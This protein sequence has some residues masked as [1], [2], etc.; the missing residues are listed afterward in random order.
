MRN[1]LSTMAALFIFQGCSTEH[2][3][4]NTDLLSQL[5]ERPPTLESSNKDKDGRTLFTAARAPDNQ[6][7]A[8]ERAEGLTQYGDCLALSG[9]GVRSAAFS[10]GVLSSLNERPS[11]VHFDAISAVSGGGYALSWL[12][13]NV[14]RLMGIEKM[15]ATDAMRRTLSMA[16]LGNRT[17]ETDRTAIAALSDKSRLVTE[18]DLMTWELLN[19]IYPVPIIFS[20]FGANLLAN[21]AFSWRWNIGVPRLM[22]ERKIEQTFLQGANNQ[23]AVP[24]IGQLRDLLREGDGKTLPA[25]IFNTTAWLGSTHEDDQSLH[26]SV[27]SF[28]S[29]Q[30]GSGAYGFYLY[31]DVTDETR[32]KY[33]DL[34]AISLTKLIATSG[35][36]IDFNSFI[37]SKAEQVATSLTLGNWGRYIP[38]PAITERQRAG[39]NI[40]P[41]PL[42]FAYRFAHDVTGTSIYLSDGGHSENLGVLPL[43]LRGC[44]R[45]TIVDAEEDASFRF[46]AYFLLRLA[47][48]EEF[49]LRLYVGEIEAGLDV[50]SLLDVTKKRSERKKMI[51]SGS[52]ATYSPQETEYLRHIGHDGRPETYE[53]IFDPSSM[54]RWERFARK[55]VMEGKIVLPDGRAID[56]RYI[57]LAYKPDGDPS[58]WRAPEKAKFFAATEPGYPQYYNGDILKPECVRH[59]KDNVKDYYLCIKQER[60]KKKL[61][62]G[63]PSHPFPQQNTLSQNF[64][65]E[66]FEA[67]VALGS[68]IGAI[69]A[70]DA[71]EIKPATATTASEP[72]RL[73]PKSPLFE[74]SAYTPLLRRI[75]IWSR[76]HPEAHF[77]S[78]TCAAPV[79]PPVNA[80]R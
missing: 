12:Y 31:P 8:S 56:I 35:G 43:I 47:L 40:L 64:S 11:L 50:E 61:Y 46:E 27:F 75:S 13:A 22:Y 54:E 42:Y 24:G 59:S 7:F 70:A 29:N 51:A 17:T 39:H 63:A 58:D 67:Y 15:T 65:S 9:G 5:Q 79:Q 14:W 36:A 38:N 2:L 41:F 60:M 55:P 21:A 57:K 73:M 68:R 69:A 71:W 26:D 48:Q 62:F 44:K 77:L 10:I 33:P 16:T 37:D 80:I 6:P 20:A 23:A 72:N 28:S 53:R 25:F 18:T 52:F 32:A 78:E 66:Q 30:Y 1:A 45:I 4:Y 34:T 19:F 49:K 76:P 74:A 3:R